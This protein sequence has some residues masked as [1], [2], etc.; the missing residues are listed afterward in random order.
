MELTT[1]FQHTRL[2]KQ[3]RK[4]DELAGEASKRMGLAAEHGDLRENTEFQYAEENRNS[5]LLKLRR[6][7]NQLE[8]YQILHESEIS[9]NFVGIGTS[10]KVIDLI[11][12]RKDVFNIVGSGP[13]DI[14]RDE[15]GYLSPIGE[16]LCGMKTGEVK[17]VKVPVGTRKY[18]VLEIS[19]YYPKE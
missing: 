18:Q 3:M 7:K 14:G 4:L 8:D 19:K 17:T 1:L 11:T 16:G 2:V 10:A 5:D 9:T 12:D 6:L 15:V 13:T